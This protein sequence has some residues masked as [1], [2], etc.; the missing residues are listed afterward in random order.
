MTAK[1]P[2]LKN[3]TQ[4]VL[5]YFKLARYVTMLVLSRHMNKICMFTT[6]TQVRKPCNCKYTQAYLDQF[7]SDLVSAMKM[8]EILMIK[9]I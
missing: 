5:H 2:Y 8:T 3:W 7:R 4:T 9:L 6:R 1:T